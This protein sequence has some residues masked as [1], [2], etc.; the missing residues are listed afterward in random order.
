[1]ELHDM[2]DHLG[3]KLRWYRDAA[4]YADVLWLAHRDGVRRPLEQAITEAGCAKLMWG[5]TLPDACLAYV[6]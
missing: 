6:W 3:D 5:E 4:G 2:A 1:V